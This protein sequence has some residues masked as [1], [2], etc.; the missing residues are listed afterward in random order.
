MIHIEDFFAQYFIHLK[1]T[2]KAIIQV[3]KMKYTHFLCSYVIAVSGNA[4][5]I[6]VSCAEK[7]IYIK[8]ESPKCP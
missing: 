4:C 6:E 5:K 1:V 2:F 3:A 8:I 7:R